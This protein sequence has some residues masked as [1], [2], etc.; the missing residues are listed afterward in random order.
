MPQKKQQKV[1]R[2]DFVSGAAGSVAMVP[3]LASASGTNTSVAAGKSAREIE[4]GLTYPRRFTGRHLKMIAFPLGGIGTGTISLG[5]RGQLRDWEI[6]NRPDKGN[7]PMYCFFTIWARAG[8]SDPV[9]RVLESRIL[10]PYE[11]TYRGLGWH[12]AP[13]LPR[14]ESAEFEGEYP[15]ARIRFSDSKLPVKVELEAF[16]PLVPNDVDASSLPVA[17]FRYR[18]RNTGRSTVRVSIAYSQENPVGTGGHQCDFREENELVGLLLRNPFLDG[19]DPLAGSFVVGALKEGNENVTYLKNWKGPHLR[20]WPILFWDDF[21][22]DGQLT[23]TGAPSG[24]RISSLCIQKEIEAGEEASFPFLLAWH[25]P[26]RTPS[27]CGWRAPKGHEHDVIGNHYCQRFPDA[28]AAAREAG[29]KLSELE[30]RTRAFVETVRGST[31]PGAVLDAAMSNLSTL[32]TNTCFRTADGHFYGFEGCRD[33]AG[34]CFGNCTHVWNYEQAT[35]FVFP[36][37]ARSMRES[38]LGFNTDESGCMSF[39]QLLPDGIARMGKAAADGQM[40]CL[41]KL[42]RDWQLSGDTEW[43]RQLWP[44][45]K[46]A[47]EFA[48]IPNGWDGDRDGVMEGVQHNTYDV[49]FYGPNP[50]CGVWYLGALRAGE[51][52][53]RAVGDKQAAEQYRKLFEKGREWID[54]NL[55]NGEYYVQQVRSWPAEQIPE[56]LV[57]NRAGLVKSGQSPPFQVGD[58]CLVDQ[59]VGQYFAHVAGLGYLLKPENVRKAIQAVF[60]N[61]FK[62]SLAEHESLQRVYALNDEAAMV[63]CSFPKGNRPAVPFWFFS[64]TMTGFEYQAAVHLIQEGFLKEGLEA[65]KAIRRRY[66]G[67]RRNPWNEAECGHHYARAMASWALIPALSGFHYSGVTGTLTVQPPVNSQDFS[68]FWSTGTAWGRYAQKH[69]GPSFEAILKVEEGKLSCKSL[70]LSRSAVGSL[71]V[72]YGGNRIPHS[73]EAKEE[74]VVL[75]LQRRLGIEPGQ[76]LRI[77]RS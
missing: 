9:A 61:N 57:T 70:C 1:T 24:A 18:A 59:L 27:R 43:L 11:V 62:T 3:A 39:R 72:E 35:A 52:M 63:I 60:R 23:E 34:C 38:E 33:Q 29:E 40:G 30:R 77:L 48:W 53:A 7:C 49:E 10:P 65:T 14:L 13:G 69:S 42:Y 12:N 21:K 15:F 47:L 31:L 56:P 41:M 67:E 22:R 51:E 17:V 4:G 50:Q 28:W 2:R 58:G 45:A 73:V 75:Q 20:V 55:F 74:S 44:K 5:G 16:N 19:K 25:F 26:N 66:D 46:T 6:F 76:P 32:R 71:R 8:N 68:T 36:S 54:A 64:E 37:L